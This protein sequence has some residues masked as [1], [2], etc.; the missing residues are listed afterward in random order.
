MR[1]YIHDWGDHRTVYINDLAGFCKV[2][3]YGE[4]YRVVGELYDLV[5]YPDARGI[6][7]GRILLAEAEK[8]AREAGCDFLVLWPDCELWVEDWYRRNGF[9]PDERF[10][11]YDGEPGWAKSL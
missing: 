8:A 11:N 4:E 6:G 9:E 7:V 10:H 1:T 2:N 3:V 5:V